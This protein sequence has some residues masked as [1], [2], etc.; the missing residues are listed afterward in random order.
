MT[1]RLLQYRKQA[2]DL[3]RIV[4]RLY[5]RFSSVV[6]GGMR[7]NQTPYFSLSEHFFRLKLLF[8][9]KQICD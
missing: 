9:K 5:T 8:R 3:N 4:Q 6:A 2:A 7:G 1:D